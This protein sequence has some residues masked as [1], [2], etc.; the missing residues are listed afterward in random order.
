M[1]Q[2]DYYKI[3]GVDKNAGIDRIKEAYRNLAFEYHPD[4]NSDKPQTAEKMK[5]INEAYA[6]LSNSSKRNEYDML[7]RQYGSTAYSQFRNTYSEQDI[8]NGSDIGH[9]FEEMAKSFGFR[10]YD[11]I[12]REF[13][14]KGY[15]TFE[16]KRPGV[17]V[18]GSIF[19][20]GLGHRSRR[21]PQMPVG[22]YLGKLSQLLFQKI[23]GVEMGVDIRGT[24]FISGGP[25]TDE[26][27]RNALRFLLERRLWDRGVKQN[28]L[29]VTIDVRWLV[30]RDA[31][32]SQFVA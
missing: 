30:A 7:R 22:G 15:R 13:Y 10:G 16:F 14:G 4:R 6:V 2:E 31:H 17:F 27:I 18:R 26:V 5:Q 1:T 11:E 12:F 23:S 32:H 8:F 24:P 25:L 20:G 29:V 28:G 19:I 9:I 3:L 21:L